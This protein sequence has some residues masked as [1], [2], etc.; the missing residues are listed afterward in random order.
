MLADKTYAVYQVLKARI[1]ADAVKKGIHLQDEQKVGAFLVSLFE[2]DHGSIVVAE[3]D[4]YES[5]ANGGNTFV[6]R[7]CHK[8]I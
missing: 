2:P 6:F 5:K 8:F 3:A 7:Q 4:M 1:R